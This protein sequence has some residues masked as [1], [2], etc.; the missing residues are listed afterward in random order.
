MNDRDLLRHERLDRVNTCG[1][2]N[3]A[4]L[5]AGSE[6]ITRFANVATFSGKLDAFKVGQLRGPASLQALLDAL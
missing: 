6:G 5:P 2:E 3:L 1:I 4:D